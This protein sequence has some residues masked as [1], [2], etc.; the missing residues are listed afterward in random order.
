MNDERVPWSVTAT[1]RGTVG[2]IDTTEEA[3]S[4]TIVDLIAMAPVGTAVDAI[5]FEPSRVELKLRPA[6]GL[7]PERSKGMQRND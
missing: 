3:A 6:E 7:L 1:L 2:H 5:E 4:T